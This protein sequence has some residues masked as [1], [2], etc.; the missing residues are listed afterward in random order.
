[1]SAPK[2][3]STLNPAPGKSNFLICLVDQAYQAYL[4]KPTKP[5]TRQIKKFEIHCCV[6]LPLA[7]RRTNSYFE[8]LFFHLVGTNSY[9][10]RAAVSIS[11]GCSKVAADN[12]DITSKMSSEMVQLFFLNLCWNLA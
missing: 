4:T 12:T 5:T 9:M 11:R 7:S 3:Q 2:S 10:I 8:N 1:M 6:S